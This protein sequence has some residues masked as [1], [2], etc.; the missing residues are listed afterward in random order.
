VELISNWCAY[1]S[2]KK[3]GG[4]GIVEQQTGLPI[5]HRYLEC[6]HAPASGMA[7]SDLALIALDFHD[8]NCVDCKFRESVGLPNL[9]TLLSQRDAHRAQQRQAQQ[10]AEQQVAER[11][12]ARESARQQMRPYLDTMAATT[13]DQISELDRTRRMMPPIVWFRRQNSP[14]KHFPVRLSSISSG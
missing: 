1:V 10:R 4:T 14:R 2:I 13:L 3:S 8:R 12:A 9:T 7:G 5:G 11:L 6:Q